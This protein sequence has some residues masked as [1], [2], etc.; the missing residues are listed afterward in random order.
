MAKEITF[1]KKSIEDEL[2]TEEGRYIVFTVTGF[3]N[4]N[5]F[6]VSYHEREKKGVKLPVWGCNNQIVTHWLKEIK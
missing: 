2:P 5:T 6:E 3:G 4:K 1:V